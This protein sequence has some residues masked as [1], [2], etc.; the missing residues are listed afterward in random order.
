MRIRYC[1]IIDVRT[2]RRGRSWDLPPI[3]YG[4]LEPAQL[5][6]EAGLT[7]EEVIQRTCVENHPGHGAPQASGFAS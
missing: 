6:G 7:A 1:F 4:D 2:G 5:T 3:S